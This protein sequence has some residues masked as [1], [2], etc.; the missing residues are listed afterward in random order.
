MWFCFIIGREADSYNSKKLVVCFVCVLNNWCL[1]VVCT[2]VC[3]CVDLKCGLLFFF[4][5]FI[6]LTQFTYDIRHTWVK[7][8]GWVDIRIYIYNFLANTNILFFSLEFYLGL[9]QTIMIFKIKFI[10]PLNNNVIF[11]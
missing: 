10:I 1:H 4:H 11:F 5:S 9:V 7:F 2:Y 8:K 3:V 6:V